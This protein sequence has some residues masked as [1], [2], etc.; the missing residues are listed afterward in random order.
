MY[1][2]IELDLAEGRAARKSQ[3]A[4]GAIGILFL[5]LAAASY[6]GPIELRWLGWGIA[7]S[8]LGIISIYVIIGWFRW[9]RRQE[10]LSPVIAFPLGYLVWYGLGSLT[11]LGESDSRVWMYSSVGLGCYL[12]GAAIGGRKVL[13]A[14]AK[15]HIRDDWDDSHF[16][17]VMAVFAA[18]AL[19]AYVY[20]ILQ[21]GVPALDP[22]AAERRLEVT[23]YG[24][25]EAV[26]FTASWTLLIFAA[27]RL[28]TSRN[29]ALTRVVAWAGMGV[30][31]FML[32]SL[33]SRGFLF[34][35][36]LTAIIARHYLR[37]RF[38][39]L[40]LTV[41]GSLIF[42]GLSIYGYTRDSTLPKELLS[43]HKD[44]VGELAIFPLIYAYLY[45]RQPVETFQQITEII[46]RTIPYQHG[47]LT[48]GALRT[49][50]PGH[51]EMSDMYFKQIL[52][53]DFTGGGQPA[54]VLGPFYGDFGPAGIVIGMFAV[55]FVVANVYRW[56][57]ED[58]TVFR[59]LI[60]AWVMQTLL[61]SLFGAIF[62]YITTIW[63][64]FFWWLV[65]SLVLKR[66]ARAAL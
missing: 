57:L 64:P 17:P 10:L 6:A 49:L 47:Q 41:L 54:T 43:A 39:P 21:M 62:P 22:D 34:V 46:P 15:P 2:P 65:H 24:P 40:T 63:I 32:L 23:K 56:M 37:K 61:F 25:S 16:W 35:P 8:V 28:W 51:H 5:L 11:L 20:V 42:V 45:V 14:N 9:L 55:G 13:F 29:A 26:L 33:G 19:L 53:S 1:S 27:A 48:F 38:H 59:V 31:A 4:A 52:G 66:R 36:L 58:P 30:V 60:Y 18:L 3:I 50:L 44:S 7:S 12:L